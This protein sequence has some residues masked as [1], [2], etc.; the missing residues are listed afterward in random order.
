[1]PRR[2]FNIEEG[3]YRLQKMDE[4]SCNQVPLGNGHSIFSC[5]LH[6]LGE[7]NQPTFKMGDFEQ[8]IMGEAYSRIKNSVAYP[9]A[10][11]R[12]QVEFVISPQKDHDCYVS[13]L[14]EYKLAKNLSCAIAYTPPLRKI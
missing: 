13:P 5:R 10:G 7:R 4:I 6:K 1:M 8:I 9:R 11:R 2:N 3:S 14:G 12:P